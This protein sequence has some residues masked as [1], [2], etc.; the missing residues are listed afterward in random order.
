MTV[1]LNITCNDSECNWKLYLNLAQ[2]LLNLFHA[3]LKLSMLFMPMQYT[4]I[5]HGCKNDNFLMKN[6]NVFLFLLKT[7]I[8]GSS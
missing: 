8:V 4:V 6:C 2:R 1:M 5:F 3:Q 7:L